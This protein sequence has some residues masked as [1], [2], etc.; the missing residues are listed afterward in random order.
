MHP[1]L[2][3]PFLPALQTFFSSVSDRCGIIDQFKFPNFLSACSGTETASQQNDL[4]KGVSTFLSDKRYATL[5][6]LYSHST[7]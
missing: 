7:S 5:G 6:S 3:M 1:L 4:I 2:Q